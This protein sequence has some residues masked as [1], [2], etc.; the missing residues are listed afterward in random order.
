MRSKVTELAKRNKE[1]IRALKDA[2]YCFKED[3]TKVVVSEE[4][5]EAWEK[6]LG[7]RLTGFKKEKHGS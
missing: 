7:K 4:R 3:G 1:L 6:A 5:V 2:V